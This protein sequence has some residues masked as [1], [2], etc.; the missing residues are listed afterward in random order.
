M[1]PGRARYKSRAHVQDA[2]EIH[3]ETIGFTIDIAGNALDNVTHYVRGIMFPGHKVDVRL[4]KLARYEACGH[5]DW[6]MD[7]THSDKH[8]ATLLVGRGT[9]HFLGG[10]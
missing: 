7:S 6:H 4:Y 1:G 10:W 9:Q 2:S 5:F 3:G 8:H